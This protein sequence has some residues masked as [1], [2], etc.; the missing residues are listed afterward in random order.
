MNEIEPSDILP[1]LFSFGVF[2]CCYYGF[3][4][5]RR[6]TLMRRYYQNPRLL[7]ESSDEYIIT[8]ENQGNS[9]IPYQDPNYLSIPHNISEDELP[10]YDDV[11]NNTN[12]PDISNS[13]IIANNEPPP[14]YTEC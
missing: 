14:N 1:I 11:I 3:C 6:E 7:V 9:Y 4:N 10:K 5:N 13:T 12:L 8:E 2:I